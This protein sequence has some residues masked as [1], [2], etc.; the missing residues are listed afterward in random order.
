M[1]LIHITG[2]LQTAHIMAFMACLQNVVSCCSELNVVFF[3]IHIGKFFRSF[4]SSFSIQVK[5]LPLQLCRHCVPPSLY[6]QIFSF[7]QNWHNRNIAP[8][9]CIKSYNVGRDHE[10]TV[11]SGYQTNTTFMLLYW[12]DIY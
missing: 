2:V 7:S 10:G 5:C 8:T 3:F 12:F 6:F 9:E 11:F 4:E 1:K